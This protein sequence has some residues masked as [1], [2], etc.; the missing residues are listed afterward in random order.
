MNFLR[1]NDPLLTVLFEDEDI[2]AINKP[3]GLNAHTNDSKIEHSDFIQ[4]GLIEIYE[5]NLNRKL[6][7]IHRLDQTT[8]GVMIFGKSVE[9]SKKFAEFFFHRQVQKTYWMITKKRSQKSAFTEN[10]IIIHKGK[11]LE[12]LTD[13]KRLN[14]GAGFELWEAKPHTGRNHQIRIHAQAQGISILGDEK[15]D[16]DT[17]PFLCLHNRRIEFPNG[18][19]IESEPPKYFE[20]LNYLN[21]P[22]LVSLLFEFDRRQRL[23]SQ[24]T[25]SQHY[26]I[27]QV[28]QTQSMPSYTLDRFDRYLLFSWSSS[29]I[30]QKELDQINEFAKIYHFAVAVQLKIEKQPNKNQT[31]TKSKQNQAPDSKSHLQPTRSISSLQWIDPNQIYSKYTSDDPSSELGFIQEGLLKFYLFEG[32][33]HSFGLYSSQRL[34][35]N[36]LIQNSKDQTVLNLFAFTGTYAIAAVH[37]HAQKVILVDQQKK[38]LNMAQKNYQLNQMSGESSQFLLRDSLTYIEQCRAKNIKFDIVVCDIPSFLRR[39]KGFFKVEK[40]FVHLISACLSILNSKGKIIF[41]LAAEEMPVKTIFEQLSLVRNQLKLTDLQ[42]T[43]ILP[44]LDFE[45]PG[46]KKIFKSFILQLKL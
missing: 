39:E 20:N 11:E 14:T 21:Q 45:L 4:D 10:K 16:G 5:K 36:W 18:I 27:A 22:L 8:T 12:A 38:H 17:F 24:Q 13:F 40:D 1:L 43:S 29:H 35:R 34:L 23:F 19:T 46:Q 7:I 2:I 9:S 44:P 32:L 25:N 37:G 31:V 30:Q 15:Y 3:Y 41:T 6:H 26:R 33:H 28:V 42:L